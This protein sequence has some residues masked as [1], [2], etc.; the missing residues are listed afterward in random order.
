MRLGDTDTAEAYLDRF[1][2]LGTTS[3]AVGGLFHAIRLHV[4]VQSGRMERAAG[5][6]DED[7]SQTERPDVTRFSSVVV[8]VYCGI[9]RAS[10]GQLAEASRLFNAALLLCQ[11][12]AAAQMRGY[13]LFMFARA[14]AAAH[15]FTRAAEAADQALQVLEPAADMS[16]IVGALNVRAQ[17]AEQL[18]DLSTA[19]SLYARALRI[20]RAWNT[21]SFNTPGRSSVWPVCHFMPGSRTAHCAFLLRSTDTLSTAETSR[22]GMCSSDPNSCSVV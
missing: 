3:D 22:P 16:I 5:Y 15:D 12:P 11:E 7:L 1:M 19:G 21:S 10:S 20:V 13:T 4:A 6:A 9:I 2:D 18:A 14:Q 8:L 17:L